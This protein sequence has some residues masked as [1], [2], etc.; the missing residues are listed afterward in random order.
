VTAPRVLAIRSPSSTGQQRVS[1]LAEMPGNPGENQE[2]KLANQARSEPSSKCLGCLPCRRSVKPALWVRRWVRKRSA[3]K[4][5]L[6]EPQ[7]GPPCRVW[8]RSPSLARR[9]TT[10]PLQG[11]PSRPSTP[12]ELSA[13][14]DRTAPRSPKHGEPEIADSRLATPYSHC[15]PR[16]LH[17]PAVADRFQPWS[18]DSYAVPVVV[19]YEETIS[20]PMCLHGPSGEAVSLQPCKPVT[21]ITKSCMMVSYWPCSQNS[22][23]SPKQPTRLLAREAPR[24]KANRVRLRR[25]SFSLRLAILWLGGFLGLV[26]AAHSL[27]DR[28]PMAR[29][30]PE[31]TGRGQC[32]IF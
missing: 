26:L 12:P 28:V 27:I 32:S 29:N 31:R 2:L 17:G 20:W 9:S 3:S 14:R 7:V 15:T 22:G 19:S 6:P 10:D 13:P 30:L 18:F 11:R 25:V 5:I 16:T 1:D 21:Q 24:A 8:P 23:L 4:V